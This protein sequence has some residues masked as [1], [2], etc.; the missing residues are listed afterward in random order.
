MPEPCPLHARLQVLWDVQQG[1]PIC[2]TPTGNGF[3]LCLSFFN[4]ASDKMITAGNNNM[5]VWT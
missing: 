4:T 2:G 3:T 5:T 1:R